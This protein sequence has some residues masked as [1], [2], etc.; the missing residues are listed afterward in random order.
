MVLGFS[1]FRSDTSQ[2]DIAGV[3]TQI[4][5]SRPNPEDG[6]AQRTPVL[7]ALQETGLGNQ[8]MMAAGQLEKLEERP[9]YLHVC[10]PQACRSGSELR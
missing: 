5:R 9:P 10:C 3:S 8:D 2:E 7:S 6:Q 4:D 1:A